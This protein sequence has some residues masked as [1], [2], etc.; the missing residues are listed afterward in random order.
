MIYKPSLENKAADALS[1]VQPM[2]QLNQ[3]T[4]SN[5]IDIVVIK[6]E[7]GSDEKLQKIREKLE[8]KGEGQETKFSFKQG[9]LMYK[10]RLVLSKSSKLIPTILHAYHDSIFGGHSSFLRTYK[11]LTGEL[12]WEGMKHDVKRYCEE[13]ITYQQNKMLALSPAELLTPLE[14]LGKVWEDISMNFIEGLPEVNGWKVI[15]VVVDRFSK[16]G[17]F[18]PLKH[19]L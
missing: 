2:V 14:V 6:E 12:Y 4:A 15:F 19:P 9:I 5:I 10:D 16:Y 3:S 1:R 13:C 11:R 8:E 18:L 17:H 7:I